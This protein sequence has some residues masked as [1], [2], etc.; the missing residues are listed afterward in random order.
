MIKLLITDLDDTLY[1]WIGFFI[2]AFYEM[3]DELSAILKKDKQELLAEYKHVHQEKR[4]VEHPYATAYLPSVR[5]AYP[6]YRLEDIVKKLDPVFHRFNSSRKKN[7]QLYPH[8]EETLTQLWSSGVKIV[9][10]TESTEENGFYRLKRLGIDH[11]FCK[12]YVSDSLYKNP[13]PLLSSEKTVVVYGRKPDPQLLKQICKNEYVS[14]NEAIYVG[15]SMTKDIYMARAAHVTSILCK[16]PCDAQ[17]TQ[18]LYQK[19]VA[20]SH[21]TDSDFEREAQL[22]TACQTEH[23]QP[24]YT[25]TSFDSIIK[26]HK[27]LNQN[28]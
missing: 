13:N 28:S 10:Y 2:P 19:L 27:D 8:V 24:D 6:N 20:I 15:D 7:L 12:V 18:D 3:V 4:N 9:G 23:I 11:L 17:T 5:T 21:W 14:T 25:I 22:K 1:S 26:I 16:Y